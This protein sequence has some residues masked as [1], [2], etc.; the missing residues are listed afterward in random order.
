MFIG[1]HAVRRD[2]PLEML[3]QP[4]PISLPNLSSSVTGIDCGRA[5]TVVTT[6]KDGVFTLGH[7]GYGQCGRKIIE[8]EDYQRQSTVHRIKTEEEFTGVVCGQDHTYVFQLLITSMIQAI[9]TREHL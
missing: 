6:A 5:H 4:V 8:C 9:N 7:N 1:Y 2:K 3:V